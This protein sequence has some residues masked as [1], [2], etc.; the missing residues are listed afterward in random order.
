MNRMA[1][2]RIRRQGSEF[3][4]CI[5]LDE[6]RR[7]VDFSLL[8]EEESIYHN[9]YIGRVEDIVPGIHAA[10]VRIQKERRCFLPLEELRAPVF[11]KKQSKHKPICIG[12]E[13][14]VQVTQDAR[15]SKEAVASAGLSLQGKCSV[16][17]TAN[18]TLSVSKKLKEPLRK[19]YAE[20]LNRLFPDGGE[21]SE[22]REFGV[23]IRTG[24]SAYPMEVVEADVLALAEQYRRLKEETVHK[25]AFALLYQD[26]P[27]Y[28]AKLK[29][30]D[31]SEIDVIFTDQPDILAQ[32]ERFYP[33]A[34]MKLKPYADEEISL[35]RMYRIQTTIEALASPRVWLPSGAN[36][37][38]EQL[39]TLTF[40]DVNSAKHPS[41]K[42][43]TFLKVNLEAAEE[44]ARQLKLRNISG[45]ILVDFINLTSA[46]EK[47]LLAYLKEELKKDSCPCRFIDITKLG[48]VELTRKKTQK[49]LKEILG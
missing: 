41:A 48:L 46:E 4:A 3:L 37:I 43:D 26:P 45:M 27:A 29:S 47:T 36:I 2:T 22:E 5:V 40:I 10:F 18:R 11:T 30:V 21:A 32:V 39:E 16:L 34:A 6:K 23:V 20:M 14:L 31:L 38:I 24:A 17:T 9:I 12:D 44:I 19:T 7:F 42:P 49:S 15:K 28:I 25:A 1:I 33:P 8:K 35:D 13:L